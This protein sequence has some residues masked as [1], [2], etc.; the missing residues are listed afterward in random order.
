MSVQ[1]GDSIVLIDGRG[2]WTVHRVMPL[3]RVDGNDFRL[4]GAVWRT[5]PF[6]TIG[7]R[8]AAGRLEFRSPAQAIGPRER[9]FSPLYLPHGWNQP[10]RK[11][12]RA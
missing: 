6:T 2:C 10:A 11:A 7:T 3:D 9:P 4:S 8:D 12:V 5:F 1:V